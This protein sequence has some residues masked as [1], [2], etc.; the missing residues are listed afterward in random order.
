MQYVGDNESRLPVRNVGMQEVLQRYESAIRKKEE[1]LL[2]KG[3]NVG[4]YAQKIF[5]SLVV[6]YTRAT[7]NGKV[8]VI[9]DMGSELHPPYGESDLKLPQHTNADYISYL[10]GAISKARNAAQPPKK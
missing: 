9:D 1:L 10:R 8:I 6:N 2:R 3:K 7:W 4:E 5:D